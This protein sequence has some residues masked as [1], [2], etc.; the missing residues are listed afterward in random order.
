M[1][2]NTQQTES[3]RKRKDKPNKANRKAELKRTAKNVEVLR[4]AA[5]AE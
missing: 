2:S 1:A 4:K 3:I 5:K